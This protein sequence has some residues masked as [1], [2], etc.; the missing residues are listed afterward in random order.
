MSSEQPWLVLDGAHT[1]A[2]AEGLS[3][4]LAAAFRGQRL[5]LVVAMADDKDHAGTPLHMHCLIETGQ[6][7]MHLNSKWSCSSS[8][9]VEAYKW[10]NVDL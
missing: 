3:E 8:C 2:A 9:L 4:T 1:P 7:S 5:A 10:K 6:P